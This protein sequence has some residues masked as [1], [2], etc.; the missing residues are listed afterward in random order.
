MRCMVDG[1]FE[2]LSSHLGD[3]YLLKAVHSLDSRF[4][5]N[6]IRCCKGHIKA[7]RQTEGFKEVECGDPCVKPDIYIF[8]SLPM[9]SRS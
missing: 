4:I 9:C 2:N 5:V 8:L 1:N 6:K 7:G 3:K